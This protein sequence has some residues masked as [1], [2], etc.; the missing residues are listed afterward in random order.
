MEH[1]VE[2]GKKFV[3]IEEKEFLDISAKLCGMFCKVKVESGILE[4]LALASKFASLFS[5]VANV[6]FNEDKYKE[7][8]ELTREM[9]EEFEKMEKELEE[10]EEENFEQ[11]ADYSEKEGE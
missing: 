9:D 4:R 11:K 10:T 7:F 2:N 5:G 3:T 8:K 6:L 1:R